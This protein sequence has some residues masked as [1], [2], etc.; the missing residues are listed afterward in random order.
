MDGSQHHLYC[1]C[2][3]LLAK[4]FLDHKTL[5]F[6][7]EPFLFYVLTESDEEVS[8]LPSEPKRVWGGGRGAFHLAVSGLSSRTE[9]LWCSHNPLDRRLTADRLWLPLAS[10]FAEEEVSTRHWCRENL[11]GCPAPFLVP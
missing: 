11:D 4:L 8:T 1:Q 7:V 5:Y 9:I 3:C 10:L 2:L 6:D